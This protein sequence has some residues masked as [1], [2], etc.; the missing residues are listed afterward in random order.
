MKEAPN[1]FKY[2][3]TFR[4]K[5]KNN[6]NLSNLYLNTYNYGLKAKESG[7]ITSS[8]MNS[9]LRLLRIL[10]KKKIKIKLNSSFVVPITKKPLET[11]MGSGKGERKFWRCPIRKGMII[12][13]FNNLTFE[14]I[15]YIWK[16]FNNRLSFLVKLVK[17]SY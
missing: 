9:L 7:W 12:I 1:N 4:L 5:L 3:R 17:L 2:G 15:F 14:E 8:Q 11:R 13:E 16:L 10:L 6:I